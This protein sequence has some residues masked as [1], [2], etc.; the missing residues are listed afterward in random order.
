MRIT[1]HR[2]QN[3]IGGSVI[4]VATEK[5]KII[6][7]AGMEMDEDTPHPMDIPGLFYGQPGYDAIVISHHHLDHVGLLGCALHEIPVYMGKS[8]YE[9]YAFSQSYLH[10]PIHDVAC[11][12]EKS[13]SFDVGDIRITPFL[14]DHSAFD[15]YMLLIESCGQKLLYTGDY[16]SHGRMDYRKLLEQLPDEVD[17]M[18]TEGTTLTRNDAEVVSEEDIERIA[19]DAIRSYCGPVFIVASSSNI[20]RIVSLFKA[21]IHNHRI[22][23]YD[24]YTAQIALRSKLSIP[25]PDTFDEKYLRV[26]I[27]NTYVDGE[28]SFLQKYSR[29]K[30][31]RG[32]LAKRPFAAMIRGS[33][34]G[35]VEKMAEDIKSETQKD[36]A[37]ENG[38][39]IYSMWEGY[40]TK[41]DKSG[42]K[43]RDLLDYVKSEGMEIMDI[44]TSGHADAQTIQQLIEKVNPRHIIPVHTE[45]ARWFVEHY[46]DQRVVMD[47]YY[48]MEANHETEH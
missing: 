31:G 4:E 34:L 15:S 12:L 38:L 22:F 30:I 29:H 6:L 11:F 14:C 47:K 43:L 28:Y 17:V 1:I 23:A 42:Q 16:R 10:K 9:I 32:A 18:I 41:D 35:W 5:A 24:T 26:F 20:S 33:M 8:A 36:K 44:H 7:D 37:F 25:N 48:D 45:N 39:L 2:G 40:K 27:V 21:T 19:E 13:R 3:Q 46:G